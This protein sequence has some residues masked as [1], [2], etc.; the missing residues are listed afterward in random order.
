MLKKAILRNSMSIPD[1]RKN[2][3]L[4]TGRNFIFSFYKCLIFKKCNI[5]TW[6]KILKEYEGKH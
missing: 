1:L 5:W 4:G 2:G 6:F 3:M